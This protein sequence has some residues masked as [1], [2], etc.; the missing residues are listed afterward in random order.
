LGSFFF[1]YYI[2]TRKNMSASNIIDPTNQKINDR[3][4]PNPYPFP[5]FPSDLAQT[6]LAGDDAGN[7]DMVNINLVDAQK[8]TQATTKG[9]LMVGDGTVTQELTVGANTFVLSANSSTATGLEW[10]A[11]GGGGPPGPT[12]PQGVQGIQGVPGIQ[13]ATGATGDTGPTGPQGI[14]GIQGATGDTGPVGATGSQG[15]TGATGPQGIQGIQ[16]DTGPQGPQGQSS[17]FYNYKTTIN[18]QTPVPPPANGRI[19][20]NAVNTLTATKIWVSHIDDIGDD[21]E[22]LLGNLGAGDSF[23]IQDQTISSN[24]QKWDISASTIAPGLYV[25]FDVS[26]NSGAYDPGTGGTNQNNHSVLLIAYAVGPQGPTGPTGPQGIQGI[27]GIQGDTGPQG[28][29]GIQG[30]QG[31]TGPQGIQGIQGDTGPTGPQGIQG[32]QGDTGPQGVQGIQG[33][34][35]NTGPQG[36]TGPQG[37]S[38]SAVYVPWTPTI[39]NFT[40]GD[41]IIDAL[42]AQQGKFVDAYIR[43]QFGST[44]AITGAFRFSLPVNMD[45][46]GGAVTGTFL[47][48]SSSFSDASTGNVLKGAVTYDGSTQAEA[49]MLYLNGNY[50][51]GQALSSSI[52]FGS[53]Q[54]GDTIYINFSY[55]S[56]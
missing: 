12:G 8:F 19:I 38:G 14:Q 31:D 55:P 24:F 5:A 53:W 27:Q 29:Q 45:I 52:P 33:I 16:G 46:S 44:T 34:Q 50:Q 13:G 39:L 21:I 6:L 23:I 26:L 25:E 49:R 20:W 1:V 35:G 56:V 54:N 10:V 51:Q 15:D 41:G 9:S 32:I 3:Y 17:S 43:I 30:I 36:P 2:I 4:L 37:A 11:G 48:G 42:Y 40:L 47:N 18:Q 22:I 28:I 7:Q